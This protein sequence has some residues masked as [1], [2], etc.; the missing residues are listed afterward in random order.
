MDAAS[1]SA[2][3]T[4][5]HEAALLYANND[6]RGAIGALLK[7]VN[8]TNGYCSTKIWLMLLEIYQIMGQQEPYEKLAV[9]FSNRF[10]FSP[11]AWD[12]FAAMKTEKAAGQW[13]NALVVEGSPLQ[14]NDDKQRDFIRASKEFANSRI[15]LSRMRLSDETEVMENELKKLLEIMQRIRKLRIQT[16]FMGDTELIRALSN[17][18]AKAQGNRENEIIYWTVMFEILQWRGEEAKFEDM[19]N[20]FMDIYQYCPVGFDPADSI[21]LAPRSEE[22]QQTDEGF[23]SPEAITEPQVFFDYMQQQWDK[24]IPAEIPLT[25][26]KRISADAARDMA[27]FLQAHADTHP[28]A[29]IVFLDSGEVTVALFETTGVAAYSQ[30]RYR[31]AKLRNLYEAS[32]S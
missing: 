22:S 32:R 18:I 4:I 7:R 12:S 8:G 9:F 24:N 17:H 11:P 3:D 23:S 26:V 16:L 2:D 19:A 6:T 25:H 13:R 28:P 27:A 30:I 21:A 15:D 31:N 1:H 29:D 10:N 5:R 14:I 20:K